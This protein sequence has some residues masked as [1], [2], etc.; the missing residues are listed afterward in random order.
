MLRPYV[1]TDL[2]DLLDAWYQASLVAHSFLSDEFMERERRAIAEEWMP[3]SETT[4]YESDGRVVGFISMIGN[5]VGAI[6]VHPDHQGNGIG[7]A[8]M[9][10][11]RGSRPYLELGVLE[12]NEIGRRFY[13]AYGFKLVGR[14]MNEEAGVPELR[15]RLEATPP[16]GASSG[17][18]GS[19]FV[20]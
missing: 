12:A 4:V 11:V 5:E 13:D 8:L 19:P 3:I 16:G 17:A 14:V 7:R 9:D 18:S 15:M 2:E 20:S 6:F 1:E 10:S